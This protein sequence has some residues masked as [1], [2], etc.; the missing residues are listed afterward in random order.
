MTEEQ[1]KKILQKYLEQKTDATETERVDRWYAQ[2]NIPSDPLS[3]Q[4]KEQIGEEMLF[5]LREVM[6]K[7]SIVKRLTTFKNI[8]RVAAVLLVTATLAF[9]ITNSQY[10]KADENLITVTTGATESKKIRLADG[11]E[12][13]MEPAAQITYP[14]S[15]KPDS[16]QVVLNRGAAFFNIAHQTKRPFT[17]HTNAKVDVKVLGT[18]FRIHSS[19]N[20]MEVAVATGKVAVSNAS[21]LMGILTRDQQLRYNIQTA[22]TSIQKNIR[23]VYVDLVFEGATLQEIAGKMEYVYN[24]K[25]D[26]DTQQLGKLKSTATFNS[27]QQ[28]EEILGIICT[29]HHLKFKSFN[30]Q[31]N[32]KIYR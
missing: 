22:H 15:F 10:F 29:L 30:H 16:R 11:S 32:F 7:K 18:S 3:Q 13:L 21:G 12:I 1:A 20:Y 28:P 27:K 25:I 6:L 26:V 2:A 9:F 19:A 17:V 24:V 4:R 5:N 31:K 8:G 14:S 23:P